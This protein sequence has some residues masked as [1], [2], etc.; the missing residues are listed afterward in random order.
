MSETD[1]LYQCQS[2]KNDAPE[3]KYCDG[4]SFNQYYANWLHKATHAWQYMDFDQWW[5]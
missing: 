3:V 2:W 4:C 5:V 1:L